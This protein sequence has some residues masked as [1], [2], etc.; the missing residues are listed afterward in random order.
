MANKILLT[1]VS[2]SGK[3]YSLKNLDAASTFIICPDEKNPP[4]E[5]WRKNY[6]MIDETGVFNPATCNYTII[7]SLPGVRW[8]TGERTFDKVTK[9]FIF[10]GQDVNHNGY[11]YSK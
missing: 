3:T 4:F 10:H 11:L 1:G 9:R 7:D 8:I 6:K 5:G 2:G